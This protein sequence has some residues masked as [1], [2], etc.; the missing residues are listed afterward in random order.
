MPIPASWR[1]RATGIFAGLLFAVE[2]QG[3]VRPSPDIGD[4]SNIR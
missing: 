3:D 4:D 2:S 1:R